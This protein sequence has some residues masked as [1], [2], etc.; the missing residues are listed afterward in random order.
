MSAELF[1]EGCHILL[2]AHPPHLAHAFLTRLAHVAPSPAPAAAT[3]TVGAGAAPALPTADP[4]APLEPDNEGR[5]P[6]TLT[7]KYYTARVYF[8]LQ[9]LA[10]PPAPPLWPPDVDDDRARAVI[11]V[12]D[13]RQH[14]PALFDRLLPALEAHGAEVKLAPAP[15]KPATSDPT[16]SLSGHTADADADTDASRLPPHPFGPGPVST[17]STSTSSSSTLGADLP[18]LTVPIPA[19]APVRGVEDDALE[20]F[21]M[22]REFEFV[23]ADQNQTQDQNEERA[24]LG[25]E[26]AGVGEE[27][28]E[29]DLLQSGTPPS[30]LAVLSW[31]ERAADEIYLLSADVVG[32]SRVLECLSTV[33]WPSMVRAP[34][35]RGLLA[36]SLLSDS[37]GLGPS[38]AW[39]ELAGEEDIVSA[40]ADDGDDDDDDEEAVEAQVQA[41]LQGLEQLAVGRDTFEGR[42]AAAEF[43]RRARSER[44][45]LEAWL[46]A[47]H[48]D[49]DDDD[50]DEGAPL[51]SGLAARRRAEGEEFGELVGAQGAH[52]GRERDSDVWAE[53]EVD[54][55]RAAGAG[56][57][58]GYAAL[59]EEED[60][61]GDDGLPSQA[62]IVQAHLRIFGPPPP[63]PPRA[64]PGPSPASAPGSRS[65][66]RSRSTP[67]PQPE[68]HEHEHEFD[69]STALGALQS[70][71]DEIRGM[72]DERERR[73]AAARV[74]LG[75]VH[76]LGLD[77][78]D[79]EEVMRH[80]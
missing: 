68:D 52:T 21:F 31:Y 56:A 11:W 47:E 14:E 69:L 42:L 22:D 26:G 7:N 63:P 27:E 73:R 58:A 37:A 40:A 72:T 30:P 41:V 28:E 12:F 24:A 53:L 49:D 15:P 61:A 4:P 70:M 6:Y 79:L 78:Q 1:P 59:G 39:G 48:A 3:S 20:S 60:G 77:E 75:L 35:A 34:R 71:R 45:A 29:E 50:D 43:E 80:G 44:E 10:K 74:A 33:M 16:P 2:V 67:G 5:V 66:S 64:A 32:L 54:E 36:G 25:P 17:I 46:D 13:K 76:G 9:P 51:G 19:P 8:Q 18:A 57:E 65:R 38:S 23:D 62:E 55:P